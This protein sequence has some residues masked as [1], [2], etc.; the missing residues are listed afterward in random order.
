MFRILILIFM[1]STCS[2][3][4]ER[5]EIGQ[6]AYIK[7]LETDMTYL[8][9]ID[10]GARITSLHALNIRLEGRPSFLHV[11]KKQTK[12]DLSYLRH[13]KNA[14]YKQNIGR[15]IVF[16]T[17]NELGKTVILRAKVKKVKTVSNAQ[18][19][20]YRYVIKLGFKYKNIIKYTDVNLRDRSKMMY[21]LLIGRNWLD[22]DFSIK[23]D[24]DV[25][26]VKK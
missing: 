24:L 18:G 26:R 5:I 21:K 17:E 1:I 6:R 8:A 25:K 15:I 19:K 13:I 4:N 10:S 11:E 2:F 23:T 9:R 22:N 16:E 20:E 3:A 7:V 12:K 14:N